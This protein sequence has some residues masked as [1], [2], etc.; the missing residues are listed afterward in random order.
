MKRKRRSG[1]EPGHSSP[2]SG[3]PGVQQWVSDRRDAKLSPD[4]RI[5]WITLLVALVGGS[6]ALIVFFARGG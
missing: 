1:S 4:G 3:Y 6:V 5:L 2:V